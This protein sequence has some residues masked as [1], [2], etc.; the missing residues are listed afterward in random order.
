VWALSPFAVAMALGG[1]ETSLAVFMAAALTAVWIRVAAAPTRT[2]WVVVGVVAGLAVLAR[3]DL[4]LLVALIAV[5]QL[6]R[7]PRRELLPAAVGGVV[8]V[9]PWWIYCTVQ[10][11][12]PIPTS[13]RAEHYIASLAPFGSHS[14]AQV[15][16]V[17]AGGPFDTLR[18]FRESLDR[19]PGVGVLLF[20]AIVVLL[21]AL[22]WC[23]ATRVP[24]P[25]AVV[26]TL[27]GYAIGLM[28]FYAWFG[29][30]WYDVRYLAPVSM[31]ATLAI[32]FGA[33][34]LW[35]MDHRARAWA[36]GCVAVVAVIPVAIAVRGQS[37]KLTASRPYA[38]TLDS[39][40]GYRDMALA[41]RDHVPERDV[42]AAWQ[43]G[44]LAYYLDDH[45]TVVN[46]D[47][48]VDPD[49]AVAIRNGRTAEYMRRRGVDWLTDV[50][51]RV[52]GLQFTEAAALDPPPAIVADRSMPQF[53][54]F[55]RYALVHI[56][57]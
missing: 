1:L 32:A 4:L 27:P 52:V 19:H 16:G 6:W 5:W 17:V 51:L 55:P 57:W 43:S 13:G 23:W 41:V 47:G 8:V 48:V 46:L 50:E 15:A 49:A 39:V 30:G 53:P 24:G 56:D 34:H 37:H 10:F 44:A 9:A 3:L 26:A 14:F 54:P 12:T 20:A 45:A 22:A 29:V 38:T 40:T 21:V 31:V 18:G 2:G 28:F 7:G 42:V 11:G 35:A 36:L 25:A 33:A